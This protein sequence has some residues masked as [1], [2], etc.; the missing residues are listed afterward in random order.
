MDRC[1]ILGIDFVVAKT[2]QESEAGMQKFLILIAFFAA[3]S[4][5]AGQDSRTESGS[6]AT[7]F[8]SRPNSDSVPDVYSVTGQFE[9]IVV[10]RLK[11][12]TDLLSGLEKAVKDGGINNAVILAGTGSAT[13]YHYHVIS[14]MGFPTSNIFVK[15]TR[16]PADI[17]NMNGYVI[18]GRVH[19]HATFSN[20]ERA[21]GG[22]LETGTTVFTFAIVTLGVFGNNVD[23]GR[24]DD[25]NYR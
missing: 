3:V 16:T 11:F 1:G 21:F 10:V 6:P 24:I 25:K 4:V 15:N 9:R 20:H 2:K 5:A 18:N 22:H 7:I 13:S 23:L 14:N 17:V 12:K 8:D 19:A